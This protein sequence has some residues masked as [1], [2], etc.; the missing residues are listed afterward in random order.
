MEELNLFPIKLYRFNSVLNMEEMKRELYAIRKENP[1]KPELKPWQSNRE[2]H[3]LEAFSQL[4][5]L[6]T[7]SLYRIFDMESRIV[8]M[9]GSIYEQ[10]DYNNIH[11]HPPL[12]NA[13]YDQNPFWVGVYYLETPE[14]SGSFNIH[15]NINITN[16]QAFYPKNGDLYIFNGLTYHSVGPNLDSK[17]RICIAFN[18]E[19]KPLQ[20]FN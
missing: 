1:N 9:W 17:D 12:N 5:N 6:I 10:Y 16:A 18:A 19:I 11:N 13:A 2:I 4:A 3:K 15:S 14:R 20:N 7:D 8:D